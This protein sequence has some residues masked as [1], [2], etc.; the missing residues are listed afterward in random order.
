MVS[1]KLNSAFLHKIS[2]QFMIILTQKEFK[3]NIER[4]MKKEIKY[5]KTK[6]K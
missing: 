3:I 1:I 2:G 6:C 4:T 5:E